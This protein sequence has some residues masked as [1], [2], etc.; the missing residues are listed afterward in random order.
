MQI[1]K[2][3]KGPW[4]Q[5]SVDG[6]KVCITVGDQEKVFDCQALQQDSQ[7]CID[8]VRSPQGELLT[9]VANGTS[10]VAN[11]T[12]PPAR[13]REVPLPVTPAGDDVDPSCINDS[14]ATE[15]VRI[16]LETEDMEAVVLQLWAIT[17]NPVEV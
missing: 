14:P 1:V 11:L 10:Y 2:M 5:V 9:G 13:Y 8:L 12:I 15:L 16:P 4:P 7:V 3:D 17:E 6:V